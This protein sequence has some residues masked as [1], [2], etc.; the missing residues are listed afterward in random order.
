M[1]RAQEILEELTGATLNTSTRNHKFT[2]YLQCQSCGR[3]FS[4]PTG[5]LAPD[6]LQGPKVDFQGEN[7]RRRQCPKCGG[8]LVEVH[9]SSA[10]VMGGQGG[11]W[12][13]AVP[14][15]ALHGG[16]FH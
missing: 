6:G 11:T 13:G 9:K 14:G 12:A 16:A 1:T 7:D 8:P 5:I 4:N 10:S 3:I 15:G 2:K